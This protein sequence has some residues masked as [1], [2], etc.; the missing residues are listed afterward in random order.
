[1]HPKRHSHQTD[2]HNA[3]GA[4]FKA[5]IAKLKDLQAKVDTERQKFDQALQN[6]ENGV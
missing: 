2:V 1:M 5:Y 3:S 4:V 6:A